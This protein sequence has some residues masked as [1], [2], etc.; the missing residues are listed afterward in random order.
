MQISDLIKESHK[1][2][3]SKGFWEKERNKGELIALMHSELSEALEALRHGNPPSEHIPEFTAIEEEFSDL[4]IRVCDM[5]G[6]F[7]LRLEEALEA[8]LLFNKGRERLH[9]KQF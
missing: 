5:C 1:T 9:G 4:L 6:A 8:K 2:A 7:D 3:I